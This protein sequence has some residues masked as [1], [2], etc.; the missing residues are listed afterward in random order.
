MDDEG[1]SRFWLASIGQ[2]GEKACTSAAT[3][4][5]LPGSIYPWHYPVQTHITESKKSY[6]LPY[7][8]DEQAV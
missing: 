1:L 6:E 2:A 4:T 3:F 5:S 8:N 7:L